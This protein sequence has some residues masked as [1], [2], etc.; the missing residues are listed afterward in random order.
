VREAP[1]YEFGDIRVDPQLVTVW[2]A[3]EEVP[4]EPKAFDVLV[5]LLQHRDR[6]IEKDELLDAVW[7][8]TFVTPNVLTRIIAQLRKALGDEA[9]NPRFIRTI[10]RHGYRFIAPVRISDQAATVDAVD[11]GRNGGL[12]ERRRLLMLAVAVVFFCTAGAIG[13]WRLRYT[14]LTSGG[15]PLSTQLPAPRRVTVQGGF[16]GMPA[17]STDGKMIAYVS[18]RSGSFEIHVVG[19]AP[20]SREI[21]VTSDG[22]QNIY[23]TWSPDGQHIAFHSRKRGGIWT[24]PATGGVARQIVEFG[25]EPAWSPDGQTIAFSSGDIGMYAKSTL[26]IV[27]AD[28]TGRKEF[29]AP[30]QPVGGHHAPSWSHDGAAI[31]FIV[32][33]ASID[34]AI[35]WT[36]TEVWMMSLATGRCVLVTKGSMA[37]SP[38]FGPQDDALYWSGVT[39]QGNGRLWR[40]G[41]DAARLSSLSA[42]EEAL[43]LNI[44]LPAQLSI[45]TDGTCVFSIIARDANLW[46]VAS[47]EGASAEPHRV[48]D[49]DARDTLASFSP[50]GSRVVFRQS[51]IG[52]PVSAWLMNADGSNREVLLPEIAAAGVHWSHSGERL[53]IFGRKGMEWLDVSTR[54]TVSVPG[55]APE[56]L[57]S[58]ALSDDDRELAYHVIEA[59]GRMNVWARALDGGNPR[60]I[61]S[62][63]EAAAYPAWSPDGKW[64]AVTVKRGQNTHVGV[65]GRD[66]GAVEQLTFDQGQSWPYSWAPDGDRIAFAGQ[67]DGVW[68]VWVV[69][70]RT[71]QPTPLTHFTSAAGHALYP[72]W[73]PRGDRILFE[74]SIVT[75][76]LWM[77]KM[78]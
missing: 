27:R 63:P 39:A 76:G 71:H 49:D 37:G 10:S 68:N 73:S 41:I 38:V 12:A 28:G 54:R 36:L 77:T 17:I 45:A 47:E 33:R 6:V 44:G 20:G 21:A 56:G 18:D 72:S 24:V 69:S 75:A 25:S 30:G 5:Y 16:N 8:D 53:L 34:D 13:G 74:R 78:Q 66:G 32:S 70:R 11:D 48:T 43:A 42:P 19:R 1:V 57:A 3:D 59:D 26:W 35:Q 51:A 23:P 52:R 7:R 64:L 4:L 14:R 60:R 29:T 62:D 65:V 67:R 40:A 50:D 22:G 9:E 2:R 58:L 15:V 55:G 61:T 31:A 46:S